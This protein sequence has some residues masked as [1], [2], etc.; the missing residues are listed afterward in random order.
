MSNSIRLLT[1]L[2][3]L[4]LLIGC[5]PSAEE[6]AEQ[7]RLA[8]EVRVAELKRRSDL[9]TVTCNF[10]GESRNMDAAMRIKEINSAREKLGED[11]YL[12]TDAGIKESFEYGL[13]QELVLNESYDET[14]QSLKDAKREKERIAAE[15]LAEEK[16]IADSKPTVK[17]EFHS[18]GQ[19]KSRVNYQPKSDGGKRHGLVETYEDNGVLTL[20]ENYKDGKR[21]GLQENYWW[22]SGDLWFIANYKDGK[23]DGLVEQYW[24]NDQVKGKTN[25]KD[26]EMDGLSEQYL[27]NGQLDSKDCYKNGESV[28]MS[29]C[30]E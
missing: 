23:R 6:I 10:M 27:E 15:K 11:F 12:G 30:E 9:A 22:N 28:D 7:E 1:T 2:L 3:S 25:W 13:C 20:K 14:L 19:L 24:S 4:F 16:R 29:Y 8:E 26:G 18:N 5:G 21:D 17:E